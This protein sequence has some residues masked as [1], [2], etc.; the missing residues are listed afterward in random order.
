MIL[1]KGVAEYPLLETTRLQL[2]ILTLQDVEEVF[3]HFSDEAVTR[4][5]DIEPCKNLDEAKDIIS[6]H[7]EDAGCR[8]GLFDKSDHRLIGTCGYHYLRNIGGEW[9]A[10][11]GFDLSRRYWG[12]GY[13]L[14]AMR[15]VI[16][17]GF[18]GTELATIDATVEPENVRSIHLLGKLGFDRAE[19]LRDGLVYLQLHREGIT[20]SSMLHHSQ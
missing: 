6:Y 8:W 9:T 17:F 11:V 5:M 7:V 12:K 2:R 1:G 18:A 3:G 13:M 4:F 10:E 19:E 16:R 14:E 15:E 20:E